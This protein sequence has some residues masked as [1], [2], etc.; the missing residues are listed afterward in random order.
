M[1]I[2][3]LDEFGH[4]GPYVSREHARH[5]THPVFGYAGYI[6]PAQNARHFGAEFLRVKRTLFKTEIAQAKNPAQWERKGAEYFSTGSIARRPEQVRAFTGLVTKLAE[7]GGSLFYYG[8]EKLRGT[9]K[10]TNKTSEAYTVDALRETI[11]R[12]CRHAEHKGEEV[13]IFMD[14]FTEKS[15]RELVVQM[16]G[17]I[18]ERTKTYEEMRLI[19]EPP[20]HIDSKV[21]SSVQFADWVCGLVG[22]AADYQLIADS[23]FS[24][25][26][27]KFATQI[28][29][30][31]TYE[32]KIRMLGEEPDIHHSAILRSPR[33]LNRTKQVGSIGN[34]NPQLAA[35]YDTLRTAP[36]MTL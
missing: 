11:N 34:L 35:F 3:Y 25:V 14:D 19:V 22:R 18:Y 32:S 27:Q 33:V 20:L 36:K 29:G 21:N 8:D 4:V 12:I 31:F 2:A 24:W 13:V 17:H 23:N 6:I 16:Y 15:R 5:N 10:E 1:L 9:V 30:R 26:E 7:N 28:T